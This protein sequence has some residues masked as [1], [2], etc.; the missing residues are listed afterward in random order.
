MTLFSKPIRDFVEKVTALAHSAADPSAYF[1]RNSSRFLCPS[2]L[3]YELDTP[4][5]FSFAAFNGR[6]L[7][8]GP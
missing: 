8:G 7:C 2:V 6:G 5:S 3:P 4:A 1:P